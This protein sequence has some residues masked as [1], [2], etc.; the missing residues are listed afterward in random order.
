MDINTI[1]GKCAS[2]APLTPAEQQFLAAWQ[3]AQVAAAAATQATAA[4]AAL[5]ASRA[6]DLALAGHGRV[7][8][9]V[10]RIETK[11]LDETFLSTPGERVVLLVGGVLVIALV[12]NGII[13][14]IVGPAPAR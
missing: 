11:S 7:S 12:L 6:H 9:Q 3:Q 4:A 10:R 5:A 13:L 2:G 14:A 8:S 1:L